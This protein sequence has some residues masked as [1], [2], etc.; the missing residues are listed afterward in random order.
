[1]SRVFMVLTW[2]PDFAVPVRVLLLLYTACCTPTG[3]VSHEIMCNSTTAAV[4]GRLHLKLHLFCPKGPENEFEVQ[5][6]VRTRTQKNYETCVDHGCS[7]TVA[8]TTT[9]PTPTTETRQRNSSTATFLRCVASWRSSTS[10][11]ERRTSFYL[12]CGLTLS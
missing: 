9:S 11:T 6:G 12:Y 4:S 2:Y 1:M 7:S 5:S 3:F 8:T 10:A